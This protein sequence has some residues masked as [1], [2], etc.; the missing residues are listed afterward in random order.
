MIEKIVSVQL[1][2][3]VMVAQD[4]IYCN[5][6]NHVYLTKKSVE[7]IRG[8]NHLEIEGGVLK[9]IK[10]TLGSLK[11]VEVEDNDE[12]RLTQEPEL[13]KGKSVYYFFRAD[14]PCHLDKILSTYKRKDNS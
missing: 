2:E 14:L 9:S 7:H 3:N 12:Q 6:F 5:L 1:I 4:A 11:V 10:T 8:V 13:D